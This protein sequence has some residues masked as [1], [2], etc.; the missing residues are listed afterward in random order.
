MWF[1]V[2]SHLKIPVAELKERITFSEFL[3]WCAF[4]QWEETHHTT[5]LDMYLAQIA[6]EAKRASLVKPSAV[7]IKDFILVPKK[8]EA[9]ESKEERMKK[10]K[11]IWM[12][13]LGINL[14]KAK[15]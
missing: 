12:S 8:E 2:A 5:K 1:R 9:P 13:A 7:S 6:C 14:D 3:G 11:A 10:S 4:I 15:N